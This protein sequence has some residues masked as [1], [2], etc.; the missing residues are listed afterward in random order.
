MAHRSSSRHTTKSASHGAAATPSH[1]GAAATPSH[2]GKT[3]A[4]P[5][6]VVADPDL[7]TPEK[8]RALEAM[9]Q[10]E[11]QLAVAAAEGMTGGEQTRLRGVLQAKRM[12]ETPPDLAF[13]VVR[14]TFQAK[15]RQTL[16]TDTH[17]L[18]NRAL[19]AIQAAQDAIAAAE[20]TPPPPPGA[21]SPGSTG[22]L[23]EELEKEKLDP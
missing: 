23:E 17:E 16:G 7:T 1:I 20:R 8:L 5:A 14:Q 12:L 21:P 15:L 6:H 13:S 3:F 4:E 2:I 10:D 22:E 11:R 19:D 18:I 9:E